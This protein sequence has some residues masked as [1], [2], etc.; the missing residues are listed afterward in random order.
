MRYLALACDYDGTLATEGRI[1]EPTV[2][3]LERVRASGRKLL[4]VTG[5]ELAD[6]AAVFPGFD[7]FDWIVA[8]NGA[9]LYCPANHAEKLLGV[10][11]SPQFVE[12]LRRRGVEPLSVGRVLVASCEPHQNTVINTIHDLGLELQ[13]IF[14]KGAVMVLP[15]GVNKG[16][17]LIAVL[18]ELA[19]SPGNVVG[20]GDA[21][22]DHSFLALCEC[23]VAVANALPTL[24]ASA[25]LVT[26]AAEGAGVVEVID[27]LLAGKLCTP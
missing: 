15:A 4:L 9:H 1:L 3:A 17:G 2:Q 12:T 10:P 21:E 11:P 13:V 7:I 20:V 8:E 23:A 22:N 5:R 24:K 18:R 27:L 6:L 26:Q 16:T 14:N 19:L 25:D